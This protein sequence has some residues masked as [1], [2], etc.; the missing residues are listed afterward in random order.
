MI[1][2]MYLQ[3]FIFMLDVSTCLYEV[4]FQKK[5]DCLAEQQ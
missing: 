5:T 4:F 1:N 2:V 3:V